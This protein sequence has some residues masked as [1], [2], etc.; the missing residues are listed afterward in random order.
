MSVKIAII[1]AGS[2]TFSINLIKDLCVNKNFD[3]ST[4]SLMDINEERLNGIYG[5]CKRYLEELG[6]NI[7]LEKETDRI[8][9]ITGADFVI[10]VALDYGHERLREG[11]KIAKKHGYRLGGSLH[12]VHDEA[13]WVNFY[14][15]RLMESVYE[16]MLRVCPDAWML[17]VANP[18]QAGITYLYRKY[19]NAK[20]IGMC[21]GSGGVYDIMQ[22]MGYAREDC[23]FEV[24]GVNHF[25]WLTEFYH[26]GENAYP[27]FAEKLKDGSYLEWIK[28]RDPKRQMSPQIGPK[29]VDLYN[30]FGVFP[31]GDTATPGGGAWGWWYHT[32]GAQ[33]KWLEDPDQWYDNY[34][35]DCEV[36]VQKIKNAVEDLDTP[37]SEV[38][39]A[40]PSDEPMIP[41]IEALAFDIEHLLIV[42]IPNTGEFVPGIPKDYEVE[43]KALVSKRGVQGLRMKELPKEILAYT[44]RDRIAPVEVELKAFETGDIHYL[45]ELVMMDPW[46]KSLEQAQALIKDILDMPCNHVMKEY[47]SQK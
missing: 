9:A 10:H 26:K 3:G 25:I 20:I 43:C 34:F 30:R 14:Q 32:D 19:P 29:A 37:V 33:E 12:I 40:I 36:S 8:A 1:G 16:D 6:N 5:L 39:S 31:I 18:V 35:E 28:K 21:H 38:F 45:E 17:L 13:F 41:T 44:Y 46:T 42:N 27:A 4:V 23:H 11:W 47:F 15:L 2:G 24:S 7:H 22:N